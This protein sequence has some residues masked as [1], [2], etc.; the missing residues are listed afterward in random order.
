MNKKYFGTMLDMSRNGV[1]KPEQVK[2][3]AR[4]IRSFG[5]NM[6]QLYTED[7]YEVD[8]ELYFGYMRGR[9]TKEE[10]KDINAYCNSIGV[11]LIPC[12]QTLAH[13]NAIFRWEDY[14]PINDVNDIL[15]VG[16]ER[17]YQLIENMFKTL[18]ECFSSEYIHIGMDEAHM[19]GL[20]KYLDKHGKQESRFEILRKHLD[21]VLAIAQKYG[22]K[23][24]MW[25]DMF[26]RLDNG[27]EYYGEN[28]V[29][30]NE[31][32][33][34]VP[35]DVELVYW[36]YYHDKKSFYNSMIRSHKELSDKIWFAGGA[37]C[38]MGFA[39]GNVYTMD[40]MMPAMQAC[41]EEGVQ[42][43]FITLWGD[44]GKECSY[45]SLLPSLYA[46]KR[47]YDGEENMEKIKSEFKA[48]TGEDYDD[49]FALDIPNFVGGNQSI[50]RNV[51]K[52]MLYNDLFL[53]M[54]DSAVKE[55]ITKE[56]KQHAKRLAKIAKTSQYGYIFDCSA[57][58]CDVLSVKYDLGYKLRKAYQAQDKETLT[59]LVS[60]IAKAER[61]LEKFYLS[62]R[63]L[64][65]TE[66]KPHGFDVMDFRLGGVKMRL[67]SCRERL[68]GYLDGTV[69]SIPEL[70]EE[71]LDVFGL[72]KEFAKATPFLHS[73]KFASPNVIYHGAF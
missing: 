13:L 42:N 38:W 43:V 54:S 35:K 5:Y 29:L 17:T 10:I 1:M 26:F 12:I 68:Q 61:K 6:L 22:F 52:T 23:P 31:V 47:I 33:A 56:F 72:G 65:Y 60:E 24:M 46:L 41:R 21:K 14:R 7:T 27:G 45:Y 55:G 19:L 49:M 8:G 30:S 9:Y 62:F 51:S 66:N 64:W 15:L 44:D 57:K 2:N 63:N 71:L 4:I 40:T 50:I 34:S 3:F 16:E 36:D 28:L 20:G 70:E 69:E 58:L 48:L 73:W 32:K 53:G 11:E 25:S 67:R 37:W 59:A 39:S 18:R